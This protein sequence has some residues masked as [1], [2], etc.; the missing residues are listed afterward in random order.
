MAITQFTLPVPTRDDP[1]GTFVSRAN[2]LVSELPNFVDETNAEIVL[3]NETADTI[4]SSLDTVLDA[5]MSALS[6]ANFKGAWSSLTGVLAKPAS[7][8]HSGAV[9]L[10]L[11]DLANVAAST[12]GPANTDWQLIDYVA[13]ARKVTAGAGLTGGGDLSADRTINVGAGSGIVA[14]ANDVAVDVATGTNIRAG[15][16]N[17]IVDAASIYA[18]NAPVTLTD[19]A[20]ITPDFRAGRNFMVTIAGNRT[21]ANP[22]NQ[23]AGQSGVIFVKQDATGGRTPTFGAHYTFIGGTPYFGGTAGATDVIWYFVQASGTIICTF[24]GGS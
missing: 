3:I 16:T 5:A 4:A 23:V 6:A 18:A 22:T 20:T 10:L 21:F 19:A 24:A 1:P 2:I 11:V 14:N 7:V 12:P 9:W 17:K 13:G 15:D 8:S